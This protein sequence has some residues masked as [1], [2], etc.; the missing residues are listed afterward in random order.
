MDVRRRWL[1]CH[2]MIHFILGALVWCDAATSSAQCTCIYSAFAINIFSGTKWSIRCR[3]KLVESHSRCP[4]SNKIIKTDHLS[5]IGNLCASRLVCKV[6]MNHVLTADRQKT[7]QSTNKWNSIN[8]F[9]SALGGTALHHCMGVVFGYIRCVSVLCV[10]VCLSLCQNAKF[11]WL[12]IS[13]QSSRLS[14]QPNKQWIPFGLF[15]H[16]RD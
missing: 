3:L 6:P 9:V 4:R 15:F 11:I 16:S 5:T 13:R 8:R 14:Q 10:C 2:W 12:I 7:C 1:S